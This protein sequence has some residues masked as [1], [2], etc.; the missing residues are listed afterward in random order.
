MNKLI[1]G[2]SMEWQGK[3]GSDKGLNPIF[4]VMDWLQNI[5]KLI[6]SPR[7]NNDEPAEESVEVPD[8]ETPLEPSLI[9]ELPGVLESLNE[10]TRH[11]NEVAREQKGGIL[12]QSSALHQVTATSE[13]FV[14]TARAISEN[15]GSVEQ[16]AV[17]SLL[18]CQ[19]EKESLEEAMQDMEALG[20]QVNSL[21]DDI[22]GL[23]SH[24][25]QIAGIV[26]IISEITDQLN[27][28]ALN[29]RIEAAG[30]GA[31]GR[32]FSV[33][34]QEVKRLAGTS[35][36]STAHIQEIIKQVLKDI[37]RLVESAQ[38][39]LKATMRSLE[40]MN[41][42]AEDIQ[43]IHDKINITHAM[44]QE[45]K[46]ATHQQTTA[47][48]ELAHSLAEVDSLATENANSITKQVEFAI[49]RLSDLAQYLT[50]ILESTVLKS[51]EGDNGSNL[52]AG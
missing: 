31:Y 25:R 4:R 34:A 40:N 24:N 29:A 15:A 50:L 41:K 32:R 48:Q 44:A 11:F 5:R 37:N 28:L 30:A 43:R 10:S 39:G 49:T 51:S 18:S 42:V 14:V 12:Q 9:D 13:E 22:R 38:R 21:V 35:K 20:R 19:K 16:S 47:Q 1:S 46:V 6:R 26:E 2:S 36:D 17:Q 23:E 3:E 45:I 33:V 52:L 7:G 27:L 8:T